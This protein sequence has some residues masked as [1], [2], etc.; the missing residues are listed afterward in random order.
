[1]TTSLWDLTNDDLV[2]FSQAGGIFAVEGVGRGA[3]G[4]RFAATV[5]SWPAGSLD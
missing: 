3:V 2:G 5:G 4:S 1:M